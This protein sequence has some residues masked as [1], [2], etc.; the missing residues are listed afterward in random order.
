M[1]SSLENSK[2]AP[3]HVNQHIAAK[4]IVRVFRAGE[5]AYA[6]LWAEVQSGKTGTFHRVAQR[7]LRRGLVDRVYLLC[8]SNELALYN[9]A[10]EDRDTYA[11]PSME[12][13][14]R[15][16]F[17]RTELNLERTLL[18]VDES[19]IDQSQGQ[20]LSKFLAKY[21]L[22]L[23]GTLPIMLEKQ[24]YIL[25]VDATPYAEFAAHVHGRSLPKHVEQLAPGTNYFGPA[26]YH[27]SGLIHETFSI[28]ERPDRFQACMALYCNRPAKWCLVRVTKDETTAALATIASAHGYRLLFYTSDRTD[29]AIT[30]KE[31]T[32]SHMPCLEDAPIA[33][34]IVV[35]KGRLR[36]GK[37]VPKKHVGFVW[38]DSINPKTDTIVQSL[39]GRMCGYVFGEAKPHIFL[40]SAI[41]RENDG[42]A[43]ESSELARHTL[44]PE[45]IPRSGTNL[46]HARLARVAP[47]GK[48]QCPSILL[49]LSAA[50]DAEDG[51]EDY[52]DVADTDASRSAIMAACLSAL[53]ASGRATTSPSFTNEQREEIL[54]I[55]ADISSDDC[56]VRFVRTDSAASRKNYFKELRAA[57]LSGTAPAEHI[58][59]APFLTFVVVQ[60]GYAENGAVP[61]HVYCIFYTVASSPV[62]ARHLESRIAVDNGHSLFS[63]HDPEMAAEATAVTAIGLKKDALISPA[64]FDHSMREILGLWR[65]GLLHVDPCL[66]SVKGR[67]SFSQEA[68]HYADSKH[69]TV[70]EILSHLKAEFRLK[71]LKAKYARGPAPRSVFNI[72]K[73]TWSA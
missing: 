14:F 67:F 57:H 31:K 37:V 15:Q 63:I 60:D 1:A 35:I 62:T 61:G 5:I 42:R 38:E 34:T 10:L 18:I 71:T 43:I 28:T 16:H 13:V 7:M 22:N 41:L 58:S 12:I 17:E 6:L 65:D 45:M 20:M 53:R 9:Q 40:P 70:E 36:A 64:V 24:T 73:I 23:S 32:S 29:V 33:P 48:T 54:P 72:V 56:H 8:G 4:N 52:I 44:S 59:D 30:A 66:T 47:E 21:G 2:Y 25:S 19:H 11:T 69:N 55:L 26:Q 27:A 46:T 68:F 3:F 49:D 39:L 50:H 51:D